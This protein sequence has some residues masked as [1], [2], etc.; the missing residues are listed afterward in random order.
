MQLSSSRPRA[1]PPS[2]FAEPLAPAM[3]LALTLTRL[4]SAVLLYAAELDCFA[5]AAGALPPARNLPP[6]AM[7]ARPRYH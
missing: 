1:P 4:A 5:L 3:R 2:S 7:R 6:T